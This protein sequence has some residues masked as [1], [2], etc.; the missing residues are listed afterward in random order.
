MLNILSNRIGIGFPQRGKL[1]SHAYSLLGTDHNPFGPH[2]H[3][4]GYRWK[5]EPDVYFGTRFRFVS[6]PEEHTFFTQISQPTEKGCFLGQD[7]HL[8][9]QVS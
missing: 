8:G 7:F 3:T 6:G 1:D 9:N 2:G 4:G 5:V